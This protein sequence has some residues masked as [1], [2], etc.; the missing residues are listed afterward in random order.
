M[1]ASRLWRLPCFPIAAPEKRSASQRWSS[2]KKN[3]QCW[4]WRRHEARNC[5]LRFCSGEEVDPVQDLVDGTIRWVHDRMTRAP[6]K[7]AV[8]SACQ[9][10]HEEDLPNKRERRPLKTTGNKEGHGSTVRLSLIFHLDT[11]CGAPCPMAVCWISPFPPTIHEPFCFSPYAWS[12]EKKLLSTRCDHVNLICIMSAAVTT[13]ALFCV[14]TGLSSTHR[15]QAM[16]KFIFICAQSKPDS[17]QKTST[18]IQRPLR[19]SR[20]T[21]SS[22]FAFT[23]GVVLQKVCSPNYK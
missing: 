17:N 10:S 11:N 6:R 5:R 7:F 21:G 2:R 9:E 1:T 20:V 3:Q 16:N 23:I 12:A 15:S 8:F 4:R 13:S 18:A 22:S 14:T 19:A